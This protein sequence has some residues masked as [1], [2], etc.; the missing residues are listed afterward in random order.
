MR[1][2][3][4]WSV[5]LV[6]LVAATAALRRLRLRLG[7]GALRP[8]RPLRGPIPPRQRL[9]HLPLP[10]LSRQRLCRVLG[11]RV[12]M[13]LLPQLLVLLRLCLRYRLRVLFRRRLPN[14]R[15]APPQQQPPLLPRPPLQARLPLLLPPRPLL[16]LQPRQQLRLFHLQMIFVFRF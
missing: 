15:A 5:R 10:G 11:L 6:R 14:L 8:P 9:P 16:P 2:F 3:W 1:L 12:L 13:S 4:G 7:L